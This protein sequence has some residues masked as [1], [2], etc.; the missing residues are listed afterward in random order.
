MQ[1]FAALLK[2]DAI[3]RMPPWT[4]WYRGRVEVRTFFQSIRQPRPA[5]GS[6]ALVLGANGQPA[7]AHY[8]LAENGSEFR[9]E[10]IQVLTLDN[11]LISILTAFLDKRLFEKFGPPLTLPRQAD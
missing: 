6:R 10:A 9:P 3:L 5:G 4:Q 8:T 1:G 11:S 7:F 2:E